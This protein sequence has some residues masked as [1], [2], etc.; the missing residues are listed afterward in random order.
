MPLDT[1]KLPL[2][3]T[4]AALQF[5]ALERIIS[6]VRYGSI[7]TMI[8][9]TIFGET[10]FRGRALRGFGRARPLSCQ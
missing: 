5:A 9:Q 3:P 10:E 8:Q 6:L 1:L 2:I 4:R 7:G